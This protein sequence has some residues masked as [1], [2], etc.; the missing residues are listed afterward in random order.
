MCVRPR[1]RSLHILECFVPA[2]KGA[3]QQV[4]DVGLWLFKYNIQPFAGSKCP[5]DYVLRL[6]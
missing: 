3:A 1:R 4:H 2:Q 6:T 5:R